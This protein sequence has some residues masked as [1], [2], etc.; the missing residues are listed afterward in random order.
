MLDGKEPDFI[1]PEGTKWWKD[2]NLTE[3]A[4]EQINKEHAVFEIQTTNG[5]QSRVLIDK[6]GVLE[7]DGSLEAMAFKIDKWALIINGSLR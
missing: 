2:T 1:N 3:Y 7:E 5:K 6:N 4:Q